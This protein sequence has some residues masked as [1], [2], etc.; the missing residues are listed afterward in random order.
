[1]ET[2]ALTLIYSDDMTQ[3]KLRPMDLF[4]S[5]PQALLTASFCKYLSVPLMAT[6]QSEGSTL[7]QLQSLNI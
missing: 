6:S 5:F 2:A 1:M 4:C 3:S 7:S